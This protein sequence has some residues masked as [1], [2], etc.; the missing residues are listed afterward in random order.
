MNILSEINKETII[1]FQNNDSTKS[2]DIIIIKFGA[3]WCVPCQK[4]KDTVYD[5]FGQ[6]P[7]K[8][9]CADIDIDENL[10]LYV[11]LKNK[12]MISGIPTILAY[13]GNTKDHWF[14]PDDS[15]SGTDAKE[16]A[17]F[18]SRCKEQSLRK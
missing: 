3:E 8:I 12:K 17:A 9:I 6:M 13:Y 16:I 18:F 14:I 4:I 5:W 7:T 1:N 11:T 2:T 15:V 10:E